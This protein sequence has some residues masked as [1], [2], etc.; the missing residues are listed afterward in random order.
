MQKKFLGPKHKDVATALSNLG[1]ILRKRGDL[2]KAEALQRDALAMRLDVLPKEHPEVANSL[3]NVALTLRD[4]AARPAS[5]SDATR[6]K[7]RE[8]EDFELRALAMRQKTLPDPEHPRIARAYDNLGLIR[9]DQ[10][11]L[12]EAED[13]FRKAF[14]I[15]R[16]KVRDERPSLALSFEHLLDCLARQHKGEAIETIANE[17]LTP[18]LEK[19]PQGARLVRAR[20]GARAKAAKKETP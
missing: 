9:R 1:L 4:Q 8:A 14:D 16:K 2:A 15:E 3:E 12:P 6:A 11:R 10:G 20:D 7:L 5:P 13:D 17:I 18:E 19:T